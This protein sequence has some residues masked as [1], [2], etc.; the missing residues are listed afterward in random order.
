MRTATFLD[1]DGGQVVGEARCRCGGLLVV[2]ASE[3]VTWS[4][5]TSCAQSHL[6]GWAS[7][8]PI[9]LGGPNSIAADWPEAERVSDG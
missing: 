1:R 9:A 2:F 8:R 6:V 5:C 4:H 7:W 3:Y